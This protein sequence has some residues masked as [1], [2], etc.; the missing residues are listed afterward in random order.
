MRWNLGKSFS[1]GSR[2]LEQKFRLRCIKWLKREAQSLNI[3]TRW[4]SIACTTSSTETSLLARRL[5]NRRLTS[6]GQLFVDG[7]ETL[8]NLSGLHKIEIK[9]PSR[10][11]RFKSA[12]PGSTSTIS[13]VDWLL[14]G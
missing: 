3:P 6:I 4:R 13:P 7:V 14:I 11:S 5:L 1:T 8:L 9:R 2:N 10:I 12:S